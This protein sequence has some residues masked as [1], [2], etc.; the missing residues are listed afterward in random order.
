MDV[1]MIWLFG[2]TNTKLFNDTVLLCKKSYSSSPRGF[3]FIG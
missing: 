2:G 3:T 1:I